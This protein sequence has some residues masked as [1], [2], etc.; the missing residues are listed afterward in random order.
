MWTMIF[1]AV[2]GVFGWLKANPLVVKILAILAAIIAA[3]TIKNTWEEN[4]R[5]GVRRQEAEQKEREALRTQVAVKDQRIET[6]KQ[7]ATY[8]NEA[9][10]A[11]DTGPVYTDADSVPDQTSRI[12]FR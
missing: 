6:K 10:E 9:L 7:E 4:V 5:K 12:L 1:G 8:A 11:R 2:N 3:I